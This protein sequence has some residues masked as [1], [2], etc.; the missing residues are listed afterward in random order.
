MLIWSWHSGHE[1]KNSHSENRCMHVLAAFSS[2]ARLTNERTRAQSFSNP[3]IRVL[4]T[5][6]DRGPHVTQHYSRLV[7]MVPTHEPA[8]VVLDDDL[9]TE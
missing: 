9:R 3:K 2:V 5:A 6:L 4:L 8:Q 7:T 1:S